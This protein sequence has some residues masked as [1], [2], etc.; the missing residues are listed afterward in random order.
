MFKNKKS[1]WSIGVATLGLLSATP[2]FAAG[3]LA[4]TSIINEATVNYQVG[5]ISQTAIT[6]SNTVAVDRK[7]NLVMANTGATTNASP[8]QSNAVTTW[9]LTNSSNDTLDFA[10]AATAQASGQTAQHG[11]TTAF[12][13]VLTNVK[14][15]LDPNNTG[16]ITGSGVTQVTY[17]DE[18]APDASIKLL[19]VA[20]IPLSVTNG[21]VGG[22]ILTGTAGAGGTAGTQGA[23]LTCNNGAANTNGI[24]NVC[25]DGA[26]ELTG[27]VANDGRNS[28]KGD[29]TVAAPELS[30]NKVM[31]IISDPVVGVS[32]N[33]KAIPGAVVEYCIVVA[34]AS[35]GA[36]VTNLSV[37]DPLPQAAASPFAPY[38]AYTTGSNNI[39]LNATVSGSGATATCSGGTQVTGDAGYTAQAGATPANISGSLSNL[40]GG[41]STGLRFRVTIQ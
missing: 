35:G 10:L 31:A 40:S 38:V 29:Y 7:V 1:I 8:G 30:V 13:P 19:V 39:W 16:S 18:I 17:L 4:G 3:T 12:L 14:Y 36:T 25:A 41:S 34:N 2:A 20:D 6:A 22:L 28:A 24:D 5:G 23:T 27:D 33:A 32:A 15:Y 21:Q 9:T 26:G 11:G 37:G